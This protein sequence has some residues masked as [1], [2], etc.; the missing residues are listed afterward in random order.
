MRQMTT[1]LA[2][3]AIAFGAAAVS[4]PAFAADDL[5]SNPITEFFDSLGMGDKEKPEIDYR[6]RAALVPPSTTSQLP[7]PAQK[8]APSDAW[9]K[10]Y[11]VMMRE[12]KKAKADELP[13]E[14]Y[15]YR[16]DK[17]SRLSPAEMAAGRRSGG[18][19][20]A[21]TSADG[22]MPDNDM[23]RISPAE[24]KSQRLNK[25]AVAAAESGPVGSRSRLSDPPPGYLAGNGVQAQLPPEQKPWYSR[26]FGN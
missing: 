18:N 24:L 17:N 6:E 22:T 4:T 8:G 5:G 7:P 3:A 23:S 2:S 25:G 13:T 26:M 12:Q 15:N 21:V 20:G 16:M 19:A 14:T 9:P 1:C 11:D 10:D